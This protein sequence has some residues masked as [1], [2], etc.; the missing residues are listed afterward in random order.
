MGGDSFSDIYI[1]ISAGILANTQLGVALQN[2]PDWARGKAAAKK[3]IKILNSPPEGIPESN[4]ID[5]DVI[6]TQNFAKGTIEFKNVWFRYPAAPDYWVLRNFNLTIKSGESIGI[7]GESGCGK[8]TIISLLLRFYDPE[9]GEILIDN[10]PIKVF[11]LKSLRSFFGLVQQEPVIFSNS[12]L[13]NIRYG[14]KHATSKNVL[15]AARV[16]HCSEFVSQLS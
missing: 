3:V 9:Q 12:I 14:R 13:D 15:Y 10:C 7:A 16:S 11:T 8:S 2:A 5:G 6:L 1:G 4:I